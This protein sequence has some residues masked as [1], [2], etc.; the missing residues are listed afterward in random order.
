MTR[1]S[2]GGLRYGTQTSH[3]VRQSYLYKMLDKIPLLVF[4]ESSENQCLK[5]DKG[6]SV[7]RRRRKTTGP[8]PTQV[9]IAGLPNVN[10]RTK[11]LPLNGRGFL[12]GVC[13]RALVRKYD[14]IH[15]PKHPSLRRCAALEYTGYSR[16]AR[17]VCQG[18]RP[19]RCVTVLADRSTQ[20]VRF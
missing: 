8:I 5:F 20:K 12:S 3:T 2:D 14:G 1:Q 7:E 4:S 11:P 19:S 16:F 17:L 18:P 6:N 13:P 9:R 10:L 15:R